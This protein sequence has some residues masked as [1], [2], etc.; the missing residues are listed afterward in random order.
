MKDCSN[1]SFALEGA[2]EIKGKVI[3]QMI[4][5][6]GGCRRGRRRVEGLEEVNRRNYLKCSSYYIS[7][8]P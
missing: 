2:V 3:R 5:Q 4:N 8:N 6:Q 1:V 7:L